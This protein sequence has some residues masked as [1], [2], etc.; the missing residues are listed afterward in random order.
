MSLKEKNILVTGAAGFIGASLIEKL[1]EEKANVIGIDNINNYYSK[2]LKKIRL[3]KI[4]EEREKH[5]VFWHFHQIPLED[6]KAI[7]ETC[8]Q[9]DFDIIVHLAAQAGVR[10]SLE[11]PKSYINS[12]LVGFANVLEICRQQEIKNFVFASSSSVYGMNKKF[13]LKRMIM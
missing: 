4:S 13:L 11:N 10:Y 3:S 7:F 1:F 9:Y 2:E 12:N 8:K 6:E 5:N